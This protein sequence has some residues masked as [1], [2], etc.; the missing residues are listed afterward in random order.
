MLRR[1]GFTLIE[2]LVVIAIIAVLI[3]LLLPAVQQAREAARRSSCKNNLKQ[4]GLA[5]HN[6]HDTFIRFPICSQGD[7]PGYRHSFWIGLLPYMDQAPLYSKFDQQGAAYG[8]H[9]GWGGS[10]PP[11]ATLC[12]AANLPTLLC[13]SS[14]LPERVYASMVG[15]HYAA[16]A[17]SATHTTATA[18]TG[19]GGGIRSRGGVLPTI[20]STLMRDVTDGTSNT[21][22]LVQGSDYCLDAS[23]NKVECR[24][25]CG[26][27]F[28]MGHSSVGDGRFFNTTT[29]RYGV[30]DRRSTNAGVAGN[31][32][33]NNPIQSAHTGGAHILLTDGSV[34]FISNSLDMT[35]LFNLADRDD[36]KVLGEF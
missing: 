4:H 16:C 23:G 36:G 28:M 13:P 15:P 1:R 32:N 19:S 10:N 27:G 22:V 34:R 33:L 18:G 12:G 3:A 24:Y 8:L 17:G 21:M 25:E 2:L 5:L 7:M 26:H 31:C 6:Y 30:G 11:N 9:T 20:G 35:T 14:P 29:V